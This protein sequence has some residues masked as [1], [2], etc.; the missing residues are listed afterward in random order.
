MIEYEIGCVGFKL[1][2]VFLISSVATSI[3]MFDLDM[4]FSYKT[5]CFFLEQA[6]KVGRVLSDLGFMRIQKMCKVKAICAA[7]AMNIW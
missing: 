5:N 4:N 7:F 3:L 2:G 6:S 1:R